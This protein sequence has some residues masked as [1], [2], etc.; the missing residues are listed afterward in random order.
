MIIL[1]GFL[2]VILVG[3]LMVS[4]IGFMFAPSINDLDVKREIKDFS[5]ETGQIYSVFNH[6]VTNINKIIIYLKIG[7][8]FN[9]SYKIITD[10]PVEAYNNSYLYNHTF[11][12]DSL[13]FFK[14]I[15]PYSYIEGTIEVDFGS[16]SSYGLLL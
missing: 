2:A 7:T 5:L 8:I 9:V 13:A 16:L 10:Y 14:I 12:L 15:S 1:K 11:Y 4:T 3:A 6:T